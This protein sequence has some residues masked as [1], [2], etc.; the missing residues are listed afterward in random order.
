MPDVTAQSDGLIQVVGRYH[1]RKHL[2]SDVRHC[3]YSKEADKS[4]PTKT[5]DAPYSYKNYFSNGAHST[6]Y[7]ALNESKFYFVEKIYQTKTSQ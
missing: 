4:N 2:P 1:I 7:P 3:G 5:G 6:A